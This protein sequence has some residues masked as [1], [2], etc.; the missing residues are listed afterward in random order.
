MEALLYEKLPEAKV[1]C[2]LCHHRCIIKPGRRGICGVR[3]NRDGVLNTLVYG[4]LIARHIDPIEKKPLF[5]VMPGSLSY[6]IATVGCNFACRFCQNADIAQMP[7]DRDGMV[8]GDTVLP[9]AVVRA[10]EKGGC[11]SIAFTYTEPTVFFEMAFETARI[12]RERGLLTIFVSNGYMTPEAVEMIRPYLDA[13]NIDL[14]AYSDDFY[15]TYCGARLE[16]VRETLKTMKTAGIFVEVTTLVIPGLNDAPKELRALAGFIADELGPETPWHISRFH[17][18][19]RLTDRPP[20]P[21]ETLTAARDIGLDAGL[22]YVYLG[23]VPGSGG[24]DT[25]CPG[26]GR[27][28]IRRMGFQIRENRTEKGRCPDCGEPIHGIGL[29]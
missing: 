6:S 9:E 17:P 27:T 10:A 2:G 15:K 18:V 5:H 25:A 22:K 12:A 29:S 7:A 21:V 20:T 16:P 24:E 3:E 28:V 4:R 14:K 23:N 19:Y 1:R 13:A 26:C 8:M 11:R